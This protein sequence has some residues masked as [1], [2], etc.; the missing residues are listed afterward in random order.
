MRRAFSSTDSIAITSA[1][2]PICIE[3]A[4]PWPLPLG[5][6]SVSPWR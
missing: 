4:P 3:R 1:V 5:S 6:R 2:P